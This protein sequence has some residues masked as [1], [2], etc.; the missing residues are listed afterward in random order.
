MNKHFIS[1]IT[2]KGAYDPI[3][4]WTPIDEFALINQ[5]WGAWFPVFLTAYQ[6]SI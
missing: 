6:K 2:I 1:T 3:N 5:G 4:D